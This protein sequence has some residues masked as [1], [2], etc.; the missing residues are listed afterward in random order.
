MINADDVLAAIT[1]ALL[2]V[3]IVVFFKMMRARK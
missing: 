3:Y 1:L 2:V